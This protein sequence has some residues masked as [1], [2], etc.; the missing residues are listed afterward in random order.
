MSKPVVI[1]D[2][3]RQ[4]MNLRRISKDEV[5]QAVTSPEITDMNVNGEKRFFRG[6]ICV[7]TVAGRLHFTVKT[8][9]FRYGDQWTDK[10][11][12]ERDLRN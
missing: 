12:R 7:V 3:A 5:I 6:Q 11:V 2:H 9:L 4:A 8:V 1:T 10:D